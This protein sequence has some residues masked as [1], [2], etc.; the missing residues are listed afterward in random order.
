MIRVVDN[1]R[2]FVEGTIVNSERPK[3]EEECWDRRTRWA[4]YYGPVVPRGSVNGIAVMDHPDNL[5]H[6]PGWHVRDY[7]LFYPN[8]FYDKKLEWP[9]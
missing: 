8:I 9:D 2:G 1:M 6:H 5:R 7:G 3:T 4:D